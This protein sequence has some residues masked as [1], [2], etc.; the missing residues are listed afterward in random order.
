MRL[1][2]A[3]RRGRSSLT[4]MM[5]LYTSAPSSIAG[6]LS[7]RRSKISY[8]N[9]GK[10]AGISQRNSL[11]HRL[12]KPHKRLITARHRAKVPTIRNKRTPKRLVRLFS[13]LYVFSRHRYASSQLTCAC[14]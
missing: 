14:S 12:T 11:E 6:S 9:I 13:R 5:L 10:S 2:S 3:L 7:N 4:Y 8:A 1:A